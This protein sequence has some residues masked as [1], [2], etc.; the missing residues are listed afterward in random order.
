MKGW[1]REFYR[2]SLAAKGIKTS[3]AEKRQSFLMVPVPEKVKGNL[4][5]QSPAAAKEGLTNIIIPKEKDFPNLRI[6]EVREAIGGAL[7]ESGSLKQLRRDLVKSEEDEYGISE[8]KAPEVIALNRVRGKEN[9]YNKY[10]YNIDPDVAIEKYFARPDIKAK[11]EEL[12][13]R[14]DVP[15]PKMLSPELEGYSDATDRVK[16]IKEFLN[17]PNVRK[18]IESNMEWIRAERRREYSRDIYRAKKTAEED[19]RMADENRREY[20]RNYM[21]RYN[22]LLKQRAANDRFLNKKE[23]TEAMRGEVIAEKMGR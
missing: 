5:W 6:P 12:Q 8:Y 19:Q 16:A 7:S 15:L 4:I 21:A 3:F 23:I 2:H 13:E 11:I 9:K 14:E 1:Y 10:R 17:K 18:E 22:R 20:M